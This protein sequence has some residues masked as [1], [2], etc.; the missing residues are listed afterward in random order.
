MVNNKDA[1]K[2]IYVRD[3]ISALSTP[4]GDSAVSIVRL[5]GDGSFAIASKVFKPKSEFNWKNISSYELR[6]GWVMDPA[7]EDIVDEVL[8]LIMPAPHSY[9]REDV[10]EISCHGGY[11]AARKV[12]EILTEN[13]ARIAEPGEFTKRA[14]LNGRIDITEAEAVA[15][16]IR[17]KTEKAFYYATKNLMGGLNQELDEVE[18]ELLDIYAEEEAAVDFSDE[19]IDTLSGEE[20]LKKLSKIRDR[21]RKVIYDSEGG[22]V[23]VEGIDTV[24]AGKPNVGKSSLLNRLV[25][26]E[27]VIVTEIPGTTRDIIEETINI[28][29]IPLKIMDTAGIRKSRHLVEKIGVEKSIKALN[30][31]DIVLF[32]IDASGRIDERDV[33]IARIVRDKNFILVAN[34]IDLFDGF[35]DKEI[36]GI[37]GAEKCIRISA[38]TG[39]N[40]G[41][42]EEEIVKKATKGRLPD[43]I[44]FYANRRQRGLLKNV[45]RHIEDATESL[46]NGLSEEFISMDVKNAYDAILEI[47]GKRED[48]ELYDEIF[49][50]FCIGK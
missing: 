16:I 47:R 49:S 9:T 50:K 27:K 3:T 7:N 45:V 22:K 10:V 35:D 25:R 48:K 11:I 34:K 6:Y 20:V 14:F 24:I 26:E 28:R 39:F 33:E 46:M 19:D 37:I 13:G 32:I 1:G 12:L 8:V 2:M 41:L 17:A 21:I 43:S 36:K 4:V 30:E 44:R 31:A 18:Q 23:F 38:K 40:I 29:G 15:E 42:L 5:S